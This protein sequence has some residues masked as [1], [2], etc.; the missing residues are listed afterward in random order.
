MRITAYC[1]VYGK[2]HVT[3]MALYETFVMPTLGVVRRVYGERI[4]S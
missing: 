3:C 4:T 1:H 2:V